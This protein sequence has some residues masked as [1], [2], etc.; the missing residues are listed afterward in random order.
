[1]VDSRVA[2]MWGHLAVSEKRFMLAG[3][4]GV[5]T[6]PARCVGVSIFYSCFFVEASELR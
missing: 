3:G 2:S 5:A 6:Y 1:V 4:G